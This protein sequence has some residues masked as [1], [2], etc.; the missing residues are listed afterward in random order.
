MN[1][2]VRVG[3]VGLQAIAVY[4]LSAVVC[5]SLWALQRPLRSK[6]HNYADAP[7][8]VKQSKV[9]LIETFATPTQL[10]A[11]NTKARTSRVRYANRAGLLP[12]TYAIKGEV[13]CQNQA[14]RTVEALALTIVALDA[15]HQ[16]IT[17]PGRVKSYSIQQ[18]VETLPRRS[19]RR[20]TWQVPAGSPEVYEVA[21]II[22]GVRFSDGSVWH[23]PAEEIIDI[24]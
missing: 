22:T 18:V 1:R 11:A 6:V 8:V 14:S 20:I 16:A 12:S 2:S 17:P 23:A 13:F 24:F 9:T 5:T 15:F 21:V 4:L 7:V 3:G 19:S 10:R